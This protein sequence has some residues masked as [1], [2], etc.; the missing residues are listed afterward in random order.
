[1]NVQVEFTVAMRMPPVQIL[2]GAT[3]ARA[4]QH[5]LEME[6]YVE[7]SGSLSA[8]NNPESVTVFQVIFQITSLLMHKSNL[9]FAMKR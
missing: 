6:H 2:W 7:V 9:K 3:Y 5:S 8:H 1:M 4:N